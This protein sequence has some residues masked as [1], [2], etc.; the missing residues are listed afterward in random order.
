LD[1]AKAEGTRWQATETLRERDR[2]S[3]QRLDGR[4]EAADGFLLSC[5]F[6]L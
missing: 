6:L 4:K 1:E 5:E 2:A 3:L